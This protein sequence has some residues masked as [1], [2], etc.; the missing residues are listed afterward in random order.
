MAK[1]KF[2]SSVNRIVGKTVNV[3][4]LT[5]LHLLA[6]NCLPILAYA[7]PALNI[8]DEQIREMNV[9]WNSVYRKIFGFHQWESVSAF[10]AGLGKLNFKHN[11]LKCC[12]TLI[13]DNLDS[14]NNTFRFMLL[15]NV[16]SKF[17][18]FCDKYDLL[19]D[20]NLFLTRRISHGQVVAA[21]FDSYG[22]ITGVR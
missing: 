17:K 1:R 6:A 7:I 10:I 9:A 5:K 22:C 13:R 12:V 14:S 16:V 8:K 2:Y 20:H 4:E 3:A 19:I 15:R 11:W 21:I 18:T